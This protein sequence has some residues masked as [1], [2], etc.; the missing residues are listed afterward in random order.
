MTLPVPGALRALAPRLAPS[1]ADELLLRLDVPDPDWQALGEWALRD[2]AL[3]CALLAARPLETHEAVEPGTALAT[4]LAVAGRAILRVWLFEATQ[5]DPA[6]TGYPPELLHRALLCAEC[7]H[8]LALECRYPRPREA[9]LAAMWLVLGRALSAESKFSAND[10]AAALAQRC[11]LPPPLC[12]ALHLAQAE[13]DTVCAAHPLARIVWSADRLSND[14]ASAVA[15]PLATVSGLPAD[16]LLA[17]RTDVDFIVAQHGAASAPAP[18]DAIA[19]LPGRLRNV[20]VDGL[21]GSA[22]STLDEARSAAR[23]D[24]ACRLLFGIDAPLLLMTDADGRLTARL[25]IAPQLQDWVAEL[26]LDRD[27]DTSA[28]ARALRSQEPASVH[29]GE[30]SEVRWPRDWQIARWLNSTDITALP[31]VFDAGAAVAVFAL[32]PEA[33]PQAPHAHTLRSLLERVCTHLHGLDAQRQADCNRID[34]LRAAYLQQART[35]VHE[36]NNPLTV[37]RSYIGLLAQR[38]AQDE[39]LCGELDL[40][41]HEIDRIGTLLGRLTNLPEPDTAEAPCCDVG[42]LLDDIRALCESALFARY[43]IG[44]DVRKAGT[45]PPVAMPASALR[46]VLLNL[47]RNA[48]EALS[49]SRRCALSASGPVLVDGRRCVEIR[50]I[51]NGPGLPPERLANLFAQGASSKGGPHQGMGLAIVRDM[52]SSWQA[53]MVCRSLAGSGTSFQL[54]VPIDTGHRVQPSPQ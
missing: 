46:Q 12:D 15:P 44:F 20:A 45:L 40:I 51:D 27:D 18:S 3:C 48:S 7:A 35:L 43:G 1:S 42:R 38:R 10:C 52:L 39:A 47:L 24:F 17:L 2:A 31:V 23:L 36:T 22:F 19:T 33:L 5:L 16:V 13:P 28:I 11:G 4:R 50:V 53:S 49:P 29:F 41:G 14:P 54:F 9:Y 26:A 34:A 25:P 21:L 6:C 32:P 30:A 37:I 8:H